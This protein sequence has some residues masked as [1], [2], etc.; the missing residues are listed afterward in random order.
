[1]QAQLELWRGEEVQ[2]KD[3]LHAGGYRQAEGAGSLRCEASLHLHAV[4]S[5]AARG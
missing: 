4:V 2:A 3:Q 5:P 1:M